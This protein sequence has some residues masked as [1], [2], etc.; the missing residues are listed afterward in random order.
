MKINSS[1][2]EREKG[3]KARRQQKK[4]KGISSRAH[5]KMPFIHRRPKSPFRSNNP[6]KR[7][8]YEITIKKQRA[9]LYFTKE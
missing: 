5:Q 3:R 6:V 4:M 9:R 7:V 2:T 8:Y 1:A